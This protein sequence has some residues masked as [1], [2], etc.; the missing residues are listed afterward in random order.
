MV[1]HGIPQNLR[2]C[3]VEFTVF[4]C[5]KHFWKFNQ[6]CHF[7][8]VGHKDELI[9]FWGQKLEGQGHSKNI[10]GQIST[11]GH[12][13]SCFWTAWTYHLMQLVTIT[14]Y[15]VRM[16]LMTFSRLCVQRSMLQTTFSENAFSWQQRTVFMSKISRILHCWYP[17]RDE[18]LKQLSK[19]CSW[20]LYCSW[21]LN[22]KVYK[23]WCV[24]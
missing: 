22:Y 8:A 21:P 4:F 16:K 9:S 24:Q 1:C 7:F 2:K 14:Y 11:F 18:I 10:N 12:F 23:D 3:R 6:I 20:L 13:L 19:Y 17:L 15:K 5:I